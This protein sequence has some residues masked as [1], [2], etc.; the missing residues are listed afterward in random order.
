MNHEIII[1]YFSKIIF[2]M[3]EQLSRAVRSAYL[4]EAVWYKCGSS[5]NGAAAFF[6]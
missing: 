4:S 3:S 6:S 1:A 5:T 2:F